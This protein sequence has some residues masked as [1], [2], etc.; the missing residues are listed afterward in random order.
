MR[1]SKRHVLLP[2]SG[3]TMPGSAAA[4]HPRKRN[5]F[6]LNST[7]VRQIRAEYSSTGI[8]LEKLGRKYGVSISTVNA[9]LSRKTWKDVE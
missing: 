2:D 4:S 8:S 1:F 6:K 7:A 9:V 3:E 5:G